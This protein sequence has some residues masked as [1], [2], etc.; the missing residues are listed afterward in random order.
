[1]GSE[2]DYLN[3]AQAAGL[4]VVS[5]EDISANVRRTWTICLGRLGVKLATRRRYGALLFASGAKNRIFAA[6]LL[7]ILAAYRT[8]AMRYCVFV[9]GKPASPSLPQVAS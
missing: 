3:L 6:T 5:I 1:M 7:L 8:G 2:E 4:S 9:F